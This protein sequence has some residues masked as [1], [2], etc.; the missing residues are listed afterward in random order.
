MIGNLGIRLSTDREQ[1][2]ECI[3]NKLPYTVLGIF[4]AGL[5]FA[6]FT[7]SLKS[8]K[9]DT[10]KNEPYFTSSLRVLEIAKIGLGEN[11]THPLLCKQ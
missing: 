3:H 4:R 11:L 7:T 6:E 5:I 8:P 10:G 1:S 2:V 9:I